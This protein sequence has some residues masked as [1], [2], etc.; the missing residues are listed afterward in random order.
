MD[1]LAVGSVAFD[2]IETPFGKREKVLGGSCS[3]FS[4]AASHFSRVNIVGVVG[5]DFREHHRDFFTSANIDLDGLE[6]D[7]GKTF[8]W[9]GLYSDDLSERETLETDLGVFEDFTPDIP[10]SYRDSEIVFLANIDP[11][12]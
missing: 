11:E 2:D 3:Y 12:L 10:E 7:S 8:H 6:T 5:D 4:L 1:I 9:K